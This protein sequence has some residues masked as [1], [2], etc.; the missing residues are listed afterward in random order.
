MTR[1]ISFRIFIFCL[2]TCAT[3]AL[4]VV[5]FE[6]HIT[7]EYYFQVT[8]TLFITGLASFLIWFSLTLRAIAQRMQ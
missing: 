2:L 1:T 3:L 4:G 7:T 5:W 8:A 6:K